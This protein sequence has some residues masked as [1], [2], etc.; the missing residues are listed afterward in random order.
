M[1]RTT[2]YLLLVVIPANAAFLGTPRLPLAQRRTPLV[3]L[4]SEA[5][6]GGIPAV[7]DD[8]IL[9]RDEA[10]DAWWRASVRAVRGS[11]VLVHYSGCDDSWDEWVEASSPNLVRMDETER[12]QAASAFQSDELEEALEDEELLAKF[13]E[14][15]WEQNARWQLD[16]FAK[17]HEGA[18]TGECVEYDCTTKGGGNPSFAAGAPAPCTSS[19]AISSAETV[20]WA[21][22]HADAALAIN[23]EFGFD[24]FRPERG[25]M[26]VSN[27]YTLSAPAEGGGVLLELGLRDARAGRRLRCKLAYAPSGDDEMRLARLAVIRE[28]EAGADG[29]AER[30]EPGGPLYDPPP[31]SR[32]GYCSLYLERGLTLLFPAAIASAKRGVICADWSASAMRYQLDRK[33]DA[34][35]GSLRSLELTE[36]AVD[37]ASV[38]PPQFP[39]DPDGESRR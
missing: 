15:R 37:D 2:Y 38:Y 4:C 36:I 19:V 27:A 18:W 29:A 20:T 33:F 13:R 21:E 6:L 7:V 39:R 11:Q 26:A 17:A 34:L 25:N 1:L 8:A 5:L 14:Q 23:E 35:D 28:A 30:D 22:T 31:G 12:A 24:K 32:E 10:S 9:A 3:T 16:V